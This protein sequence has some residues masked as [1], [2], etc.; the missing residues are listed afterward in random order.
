M[1]NTSKLLLLSLGAC[2]AL[3]PFVRAQDE[4]PAPP[5]PN[6]ERREHMRE[7]GEQIMKELGLNDD[8]Q[9]KWKDLGKQERDA[10]KAVRDD[11][12]LSQDQKR[13]KMQEIR[14]NFEA[15]RR[16]VLTPDQQKKADEMRAKMKEH[17]G[18]HDGPPPEKN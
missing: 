3:T 7:R 6:G 8:Q 2:L 4:K 16:A 17:R 11:T 15:Q 10:A 18:Q 13:D 12:T 9:A 1:K 14:K 5:P